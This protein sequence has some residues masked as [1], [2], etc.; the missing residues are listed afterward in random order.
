MKLVSS[1]A[2][3]SVASIGE[4]AKA[5]TKFTAPRF[6]QECA[7]FVSDTDPFTIRFPSRGA[8]LRATI[9]TF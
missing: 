6:V 8:T 7:S 9:S 4:P 2:C 3:G 5:F 1:Y